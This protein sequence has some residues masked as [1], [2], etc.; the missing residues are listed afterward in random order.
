MLFFLPKRKSYYHCHSIPLIARPYLNGR[1]E[2]WRSLRTA[3][4]ATASVR[5]AAW[6][7]RLVKLFAMLK[8][9][10]GRMTKDQVDALV[11]RYM[12]SALDEGEDYRATCG[13]VTDSHREGAWSVLS[14]Q[15]DEASEALASLT[16][17][18][19]RRT[20][21]TFSRQRGF[22]NSMSMERSSGGSVVG[23]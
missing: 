7:A 18:R 19:L 4:K 16:S 3:D 6:N 17:G 13:P 14:H 12:D 5:S 11:T 15:F 10:G 23:C 21:L 9:D 22:L 1:L 8:K 2:F 20:R